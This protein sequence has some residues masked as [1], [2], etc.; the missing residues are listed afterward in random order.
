M[1]YLWLPA[2][3]L[4]VAALALLTSYICFRKVFYFGKKPTV[5]EGEYDIPPGKEYDKY[6]SQL[7][8]WIDEARSLPHE[9]F[10]ITSHDGL[11]LHAKYY[12]CNK[13]GIVEL[14]FHGYKGNSERDMSG[15]IERCFSLGRNAFIVD[16]RACGAS[17]GDV[18]TFGIKEYRDCLDWINFAISHFGKDVRL[19]ISGVSMGAA[20]V[21]LAAGEKLPKNVVCA[22]ADCGYSSAEKIIKKVIKEMGLPER[23]LYPFVRLGAIVFG[24]FDPNERTPEEAITHASV[25]IILLHGDADGFVPCYMSEE[26]YELCSSKKK[27]VK[28]S[29]ADHG[30]AFPADK[31]GYLSAV[32]DFQTECGF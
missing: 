18:I 21:V 13:D 11:R 25:P 5:K 10:E 26:L 30:L 8:A 17:E 1:W 32:A 27:F 9:H 2:A 31:N 24:K 19:I 20:T 3:L 28:I 14:L 16:Q 22:L 12:E 29:G 15:A 4:T 6:R 23:I 7:E